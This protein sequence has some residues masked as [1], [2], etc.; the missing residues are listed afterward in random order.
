VLAVPKTMRAVVYRGPNDLRL[1]TVFPSQGIGSR[2]MV[3]AC[4]IFP[5]DIKKILSA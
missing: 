4:G 2:E 3:A 5:T 1:E